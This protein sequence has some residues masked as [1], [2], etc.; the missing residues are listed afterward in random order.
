MTF[1]ANTASFYTTKIS[2]IK[3]RFSNEGRS[4]SASILYKI[5]NVSTLKGNTELINRN[6]FR[7]RGG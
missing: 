5:Y 1:T 4:S 6:H 3:R 7:R 2:V